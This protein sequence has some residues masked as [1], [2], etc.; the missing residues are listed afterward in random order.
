M[1]DKNIDMARR[2]AGA[3]AQAGGRVYYVGGFVR[4]RLLGRDNKDVDIEVHGISVAAL[5]AILGR[6]GQMTTMGASFGIMGLRHYDLD[7]AM[8]RSER[9]TGR[10]HKDFEV[11]VD[12]FIGVERAA[13]RRDFTMNALM[14]DVLTGE[15]LDFFGG[16]A[17]LAAR[18]IR[19][20]N[21]TTFAE[22]PLRVFRAAQFAARFGFEV[23]PE[24]AALSATM[25]VDALARERVMG[26]LEKALLKA[27]RPSI[28]FRELRRMRQLD[29]WFGAL[30]A[31]SE[32]DWQRV[33]TVLD[34]AAALR[35]Q[36]REPLPFMLAATCA[37][38]DPAVTKGFLAPLT[39][40]VADTRYALNM[41]EC[42][43]ALVARLKAEADTDRWMALYDESCDPDGLLLLARAACA[44]WDAGWPEA[45]MRLRQLLALYRQ[46]MA[47]PF[48]MGRDL[49]AAGMEPGPAMG[50][51]LAYAHR[52]RLA[53]VPKDRQL[54]LAL[55]HSEGGTGEARER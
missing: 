50:V 16:Q 11:F 5:E 6:L 18:R 17:D 44:P 31:L 26:E 23:A 32:P 3:V 36:A 19:H 29:I 24:T 51:A 30:A 35:E 42:L 2:V 1:A 10:G 4:D 45:E 25:A 41:A 28:F 46:R 47:Q 34:G 37:G 7:I 8:P 49:L 54:A 12:P 9:A 38:F 43:P 33:M 48:L 52:L 53:G 13:L 21:D 39:N 20:V 55:A 15:I 22:D 27:A 40:E 14:Q